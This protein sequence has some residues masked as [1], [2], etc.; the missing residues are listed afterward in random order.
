MP[1]AGVH[2]APSSTSLEV[3]EHENIDCTFPP[4]HKDT[5]SLLLGK[6]NE[7]GGAKPINKSSSCM[8]SHRMV[9]HLQE[10]E[11]YSLCHWTDPRTNPYYIYAVRFYFIFNH[12]ALEVS[13]IPVHLDTQNHI[14]F[15]N[16]LNTGRI[17]LILRFNTCSF[18]FQNVYRSPCLKNL[19]SEDP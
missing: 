3:G 19:M 17:S 12:T 7:G 18:W 13:W 9:Q 16:Q 4:N 1:C 14:N 5:L 6:P 11:P 2:C 15:Y 8:Q 10:N